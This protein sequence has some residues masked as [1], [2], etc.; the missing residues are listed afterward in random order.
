M[1]GGVHPLFSVEE[2]YRPALLAADRALTERFI[3]QI[4][5]PE[6][7]WAEEWARFRFRFQRER[8]GS[9]LVSPSTR[10]PGGTTGS[11]AARARR[12]PERKRWPPGPG[13][14]G[15]TAAG[16]GSGPAPG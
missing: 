6:D 12:P 14:A 13:A 5:D 7:G 9:R 4:T 3:A 2:E 8:T 1:P 11:A 16:R 15:R 10:R